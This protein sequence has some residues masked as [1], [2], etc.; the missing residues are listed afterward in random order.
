MTMTV[1]AAATVAA[2]AATSPAATATATSTVGSISP[3][4]FLDALKS[5]LGIQ[6]TGWIVAFLLQTE[7]FYDVLGGLNFLCLALGVGPGG[8][9]TTS[10]STRCTLLTALFVV[11]RSWLLIFLAWRAH[12][13]KGDSR[14]DG[15]KDNFVLFGVYWTVQAFWVYLISLPLLAVK[16][17]DGV[18]VALASSSSQTATLST[19]DKLALTG[20]AVGISIEIVSDVQKAIWVDKGRP[21]GFCTVGLWSYSRHPNYAGEMLQW[22]SAWAVAYGAV[23]STSAKLPT[24]SSSLSSVDGTDNG[25]IS[26]FLTS[27]LQNPWTWWLISILS[28]LFTMHILLNV[29]GTG[30]AHAEGKNLKRYYESTCGDAYKIYR[31][32]T[33]PLVPMVGYKFLPMWFK[34][35][36]LFEWTKYEYRPKKSD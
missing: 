10:S 3:S 28:P 21:G 14:F 5:T 23:V 30:I 19:V 35:T 13:R 31:E 34:R 12:A 29:P 4:I 22:W 8:S 27:L 11:S 20:M 24:L 2:A 1:D 36:F 6:W 32:S 9:P 16:S 15:V 33:S 7:T 18:V 25:S 26:E 17:M